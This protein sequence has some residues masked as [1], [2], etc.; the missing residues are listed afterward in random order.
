[1]RSDA[2]VMFLIACTIG[3]IVSGQ[4][5]R[6]SEQLHV[7][8]PRDAIPSIDKPA[9]EP[10]SKAAA[11]LPVVAFERRVRDWVLMLDRTESPTELLDNETHSRWRMSDGVAIEGALTGERLVRVTTY[12]A[13]WF[14]WYGFFP[15]S[16]IWKK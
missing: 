5:R 3:V 2:V 4:V 12:P 15:R 10:A 6:E 7:V 9:F 8:L 13:F 16:N 11:N 14:G 1:M